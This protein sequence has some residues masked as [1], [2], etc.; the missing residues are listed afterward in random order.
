MLRLGEAVDFLDDSV[1]SGSLDV[2]LESSLFTTPV[3]STQVLDLI[4]SDNLNVPSEEEVYRAVLSW[5]KHD[6]DGRRQHVPWVRF[7]SSCSYSGTSV[8]P[9][10]SLHPPPPPSAD[11]VRAVAAAEARLPDEQRGYGAAGTSS[12]RVQG[13]ADRGS[14]VSPD[15]RAAGSP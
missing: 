15:A 5:V 13:P 10:V 8:Q 14:Q 7:T 3:L 1:W 9:N 12:L 2:K 4:S 6:I 11:E